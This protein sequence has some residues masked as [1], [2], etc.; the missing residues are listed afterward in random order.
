M[1]WIKLR[2]LQMMSRRPD[3][4]SELRSTSL[5]QLVSRSP[6]HW[7]SSHTIPLFPHHL[8]NFNTHNQ[9]SSTLSQKPETLASSEKGRRTRHKTEENQC[10]YARSH[11]TPEHI[12]KKIF[13]TTWT[14]T[15]R[16]KKKKNR[17]FDKTVGRR[18]FLWQ[19]CCSW[20][21]DKKRVGRRKRT[22][23]GKGNRCPSFG[24]NGRIFYPRTKGR[25]GT[26]STTM[27]RDS[28]RCC[29]DR[30]TTTKDGADWWGPR[31]GKC[32]A[33]ASHTCKKNDQEILTDNASISSS[34]QKV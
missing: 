28:E 31:R 20:R 34:T 24:S 33:L 5:V 22:A 27:L 6:L 15:R 29:I 16:I 32:N 4:N 17:T 25:N 14:L 1:L 3:C 2:K 13:T 10:K 18:Y 11:R 8:S 23:T 19:S 9:D 21:K 26:W 12:C 7:H 30:K